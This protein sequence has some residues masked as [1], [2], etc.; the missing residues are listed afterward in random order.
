MDASAGGGTGGTVPGDAAVGDPCSARPGLLFC[1]DFETS[2]LSAAPWSIETNGSGTV[3]LDSSSPAHSG[4]RSVTVNGTGF[5]SLFVLHDPTILP[6]PGGRFFVR[7]FMRLAAPMTPDHNA[8]IIADPFAMQGTGNNVRIGEMAGMLMENVMSGGHGALSNQNY[9][10]DGKPGVVFTPGVWTCVE[11]L[12]DHA[13]PE[14]DV[15]VDGVEVPDLH[16]TDWPLDD[17]DSLRFG[18]ER[19]AGPDSVIGYDDVAVGTERV[20][21]Q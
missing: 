19:Y 11:L 20:G 13:K 8:F 21:C 6:A 7:A 14:I 2:S 10:N 17:Y 15:W 4:T 3:T 9:Y 16:H 18:F 1:D 12:L 5:D